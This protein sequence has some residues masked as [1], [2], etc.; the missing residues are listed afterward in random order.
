MSRKKEVSKFNNK[1][2]KELK[3]TKYWISAVDTY[4]NM[5]DIGKKADPKVLYQK[6]EK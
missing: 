6:I 3:T 1:K 2:F 5:A 4:T